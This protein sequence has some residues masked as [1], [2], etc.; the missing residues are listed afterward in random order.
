M[1]LECCGQWMA[2]LWQLGRAGSLAWAADHLWCDT[3]LWLVE[4]DHVTLILASDWLTESDVGGPVVGPAWPLS[5]KVNDFNQFLITDH[6]PAQDQW[7][8]LGHSGPQHLSQAFPPLLWVSGCHFDVDQE[9][10]VSD[11]LCWPGRGRS[12][13]QHWPAWS[14]CFITRP[15]RVLLELLGAAALYNTWRND[16]RPKP[17]HQIPRTWKAE[18]GC[19]GERG[20]SKVFGLYWPWYWHN[21]SRLCR[22]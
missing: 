13:P 18:Y 9:K 12:P 16:A 14:D 10:L 4:A 8:K 19:R 11:V 3:G 21:S 15:W 6:T 17:R 5:S 2:P 7:D 1:I 20:G 22:H